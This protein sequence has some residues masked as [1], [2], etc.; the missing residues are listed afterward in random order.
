MR[1]V[2]SEQ[3]KLTRF[4]TR[5]LIC[6]SPLYVLTTHPSMLDRIIVRPPHPEG[7]N[8]PLDVGALVEAMLFYRQ[9][10]LAINEGTL[11]QLTRLWTPAGVLELA[12]EGFLRLGFTPGFTGIHT[13]NANTGRERHRVVAF[14]VERRGRPLGL[15]F[16]PTVFESVTG[17]RGHAHRTASRLYRH[18]SVSSTDEQL[19]ER[20]EA[21]FLDSSFMSKAAWG[22]L[23]TLVPDY[24]VVDDAIR[25]EV[26][27]V[28]EG[29]RVLTNIDFSIA[30]TLYHRSVPPTHSSL[31]PAYL[32]AH[33]LAT[34]E[35]LELA[36]AA[37]AEIA[38]TPAHSAVAALKVDIALTQRSESQERVRAFQDF[39]LDNGRAIREAVNSGEKTI[40]DVI[41]LLKHGRKFRDWVVAVPPD[42]D[43]IKEYVRVCTRDTW[44]DKIPTKSMR[45]LLFTSAGLVA[46]AI[47][48]AVSAQRQESGSTRSTRLS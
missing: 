12:E 43:L 48:Q 44:A 18:I 32:L 42:T 29:L 21:D 11:A 8:G 33:V 35:M 39:T 7:A 20:V 36:A 31:S 5:N 40:G 17:R 28:E 6:E 4:S 1:V 2:V 16:V 24:P 26:Q 22:I 46:D 19:L 41:K 15:E 13:E 3:A 37:D 47:E 45:W 14:N 23:S 9:T 25:F 38:A 34:R 30:N 27:R 10:E